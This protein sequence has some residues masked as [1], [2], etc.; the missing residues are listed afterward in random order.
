[1]HVLALIEK[2]A[3]NC[4]T[5][6]GINAEQIVMW[7]KAVAIYTGSESISGSGADDRGHFLYSLTQAECLNFGTCKKGEIAPMNTKIF[8]A[9]RSGKDGL[10]GGNCNEVK[11]EAHNIKRDMTVL[12]V[13]GVLRSAYALDVQQDSKESTQGMAAAFT[14]AILPLLNFCYPS[15]AFIVHNNME[16]GTIPYKGK[17]CDNLNDFTDLWQTFSLSLR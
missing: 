2:G 12:L 17:N 8:D 4:R 6:D 13:Q 1:M 7:D 3:I 10:V 16:P 9:F 15:D 11:K 14:A 5:T